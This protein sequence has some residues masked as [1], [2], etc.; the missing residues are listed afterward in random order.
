M[1]DSKPV[2]AGLPVGQNEL[3][4]PIGSHIEQSDRIG[5]KKR[6]TN[7]A[8]KRAGCVVV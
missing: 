2:P 5:D 8:L 6:I 4:V 3:P 1:E 7:M